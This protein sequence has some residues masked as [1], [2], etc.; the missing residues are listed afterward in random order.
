MKNLNLL[1]STSRF[2]ETN[3]KSELWFTLLI[4]GDKYPIISNLEF[5]G[6]IAAL[7][8]IEKKQV[9][10]NI[11]KILRDDPH[12]FQ[13]ILKIIPIDYV[14]ETNV[15]I[16]KQ[17]IE[18]NYRNYIKKDESFRIK[19]KRRKNEVIDRKSF[20]NF[21]AEVIDNPV[22]LENPEKIVRI[23][24]LG[25]SCGIAFLNSSDILKFKCRTSV[26]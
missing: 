13:Y 24:V 14:C 4:C 26:A 15:N 12:F 11:K 9:M 10:E 25:N 3:A 1:V 2:N 19:L 16:I 6:L 21:I 23:E 22:D 7:T 8:S 5:S 18:K 20:I 17:I